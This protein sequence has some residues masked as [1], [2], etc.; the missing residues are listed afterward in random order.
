[1]ES[2][3]ILKPLFGMAALTFIVLARMAFTRFKAVRNKEIPISYFKT[4]QTTNPLPEYVIAPARNFINLFEVPILFYV[5]IFFTYLTN[6]VEHVVVNLA[7]AY[8]VL[9]ALHSLVH[10]TTNV[11]MLRFGAFFLSNVCLMVL[12]IRLAV[13]IL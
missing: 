3:E 11:V 7:W 6:N 1:M 4:F 13:N 12:W 8:V 9:R 2:I 10:L 5:V